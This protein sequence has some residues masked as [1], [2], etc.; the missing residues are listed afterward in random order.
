MPYW[1]YSVDELQYKLHFRDEFKDNKKIILLVHGLGVDSLSWHFQEQSLGKSGYRPIVPD[2]PGFGASTFEAN[3]WSVDKCA[4]ILDTFVAIFPDDQIIL[5]GISLGGAIILK[6]LSIGNGKYSKAVLINSFSKIRPERINNAIF[7]LSR[8][9]RLMFLSLEDQG[10]FMAEKLFPA[11]GDIPFRKMIVDQ[12][13][14]TDPEIYKRSIL[15]ITMLNLDKY[16]K[17]IVTPCLLITGKEDTTILPD[18]QVRLAKRIPY[19]RQVFI[20]GAGH[21]V[22]VQ[23]PEQVNQAIL[24]FIE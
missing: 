5:T 7:L 9:T 17:K 3:L 4:A 10:K 2:L 18:S 20:E 23:K 21:A 22:I 24:E 12:I 6:M 8:V 1:E 15:K 19:S 13:N 14:A 16:L 11:E